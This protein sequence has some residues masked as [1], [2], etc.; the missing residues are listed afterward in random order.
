MSTETDEEEWS[1]YGDWFADITNG[2]IEH[3]QGVFVKDYG[4]GLRNYKFM[5]YGGSKKIFLIAQ[6]VYSEEEL[7]KLEPFCECDYCSGS[8]FNPLSYFEC[9][10]C[11]GCIKAGP[12]YARKGVVE[13]AR[14]KLQKLNEKN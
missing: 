3:E 4:K 2:D 14:E 8:Y 7:K 6:E 13:K 9:G 10:C 11:C 12:D 1:F 5:A